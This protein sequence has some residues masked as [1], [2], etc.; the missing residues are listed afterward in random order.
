L[1]VEKGPGY[2]S[3]EKRKGPSF[4]FWPCGG[5]KR[6]QSRAWWKAMLEEKKK[7]ELKARVGK[8]KERFLLCFLRKKKRRGASD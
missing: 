2:F 3:R 1:A 8:K 5:K 6:G 4:F 7:A